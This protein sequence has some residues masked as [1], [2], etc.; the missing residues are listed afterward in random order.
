MAPS[1]KY[2][3][4]SAEVDEPTILPITGR[5]VNQALKSSKMVTPRSVHGMKLNTIKMNVNTNKKRTD[6]CLLLSVDSTD[7]D[8]STL[9]CFKSSLR[10]L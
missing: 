1:G 5:P 9:K 7:E 4:P 3:V 2:Q 10:V 8:S 6:F